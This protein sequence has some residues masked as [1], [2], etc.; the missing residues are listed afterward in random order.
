MNDTTLTPA[1][2]DALF[3]PRTR[4]HKYETLPISGL[5]VRIQSLTEAELSRYEMAV[6]GTSDKAI[7]RQA[8]IEDAGRR[9]IVLC[10]VDTAGNRILND[11][12]NKLLAEW[13]A[14][15]SNYL[16][17]ACAAH[18]GLRRS[19]IEELVKNSERTNAAE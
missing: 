17:N 3:A 6:V 13:D 8:R 4:R 7:A 14:A 16:Y 1:G 19:D 5:S 11:S 12:H 15:D 2:V 10:L 18:V 9:L